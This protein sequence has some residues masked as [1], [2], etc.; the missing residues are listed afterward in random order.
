M[1]EIDATWVPPQIIKREPCPWRFEQLTQCWVRPHGHA[2]VRIAVEIGLCPHDCEALLSL[3]RGGCAD[4]WLRD[5]GAFWDIVIRPGSAIDEWLTGR[6][7]G[8]SRATA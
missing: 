5:G 7:T 1:T 6:A 2:V 4:V 8:K 3:A